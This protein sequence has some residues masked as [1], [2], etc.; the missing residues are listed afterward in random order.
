MDRPEDKVYV[1]D[2]VEF[3]N[4]G[5]IGMYGVVFQIHKEDT[6]W[7]AAWMSHQIWKW[8]MPRRYF[9]PFIHRHSNM[10]NAF[11]SIPY[12]VGSPTSFAIHTHYECSKCGFLEET[13]SFEPPEEI[14]DAFA[15]RM[16]MEGVCHYCALHLDETTLER[17]TDTKRINE[18]LEA[19]SMFDHAIPRSL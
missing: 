11:A 9:K 3:I 17:R 14:R 19:I 2:V 8:C 13:F 18:S 10:A 16:E 6:V 15:L 4:G 12:S 5:F 1:G 7:V